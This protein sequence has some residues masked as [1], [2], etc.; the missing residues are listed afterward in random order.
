MTKYF[1]LLLFGLTTICFSQGTGSIVG[2]LTDKDYNNEPLPFANIFID[3]STKGTTSDFDGLYALEN[4]PVGTYSIVYSFVGYETITIDNVLV[5]TKKSTT[6]NVPMRAS[7][8]A[9]DEVFIKTTT[10][11]ESEVSL[12][13]EQK[14]ATTIKQSIGAEELSRKGVSDVA[15]AVTK[16]TGISKQEGSGNIFVRGLGDRY[17]VTT[18]NNLPIPS[19]D[20]SKKNIQL[21]IFDTDIVES[22][23]IDKTYNPENYGDFAGA[24]INIVSKNYRGKGFAEIGIETGANTVTVG[25]KDFYL[26]DGP[27][28]SGF[29]NIKA[30]AFPLNNYNFE[31]S[32]DRRKTTTPVNSGLSFKGGESFDIG[33]DTRVNLFGVGS[34]TNNYSFREG[35]SR[36]GVDVSAVPNADFSFF[37]YSYNTAT[38]LMGN[39]GIKHKNHRLSYNGL[40][41]N[42]SRQQ[43]QEFYGVIDKDDDASEG[44]G[45]IQRATYE[46]TTLVTHQLL[47]DHEFGERLEVNWGG[48][49]NYLENIEPDRRQVTL[50][51]LDAMD[52]E[53]PKSFQFVSS[54]SDNHRFFSKLTEEEVAAN[55]ATTYKF[56]KNEDDDFK[57]KITLGYSGRIK[58]VKFNATQFNFQIFTQGV[59]QPNVDP[60]NVD[61]YF[62][63]E[64]LNNGLYRIR[65]F[66]GTAETPNALDPQY[67]RG[68][69]KIHAGYLNFEYAFSP[70][71]TALLGVRGEQINQF[72]EWS[73]SLDTN[74]DGS[75]LDTFEVLPALSLKYELNEKQN[76]KLAVSKTYTLPQFK[77]RARFLFQEV[78][79]DYF[80]NPGLIA[81]TDYNFDV[82]WEFFPESSEII[83]LG[84]FGKYIQN[85]INS[86]TAVS[87]S[88]DITW[89]NTGEKATAFGAELEVRKSLF[90]H[91]KNS[92]ESILTNSL[93]VG[94]NAAYM[95]TN[96]DL[97]GDKVLAETTEAGFPISFIPTYNS[98]EI[99]G[100]SN[101]VANADI[102]Y[103]KD[104]SE[105]GN[106][107]LTLAA[108]YFSDRIF[109]LGSIGKGNL[110]EKGVATLDFIAKAQLTEN[111]TLALAAKNL[112]NPSIERF[113][114]AVDGDTNPENDG[115]QKTDVTILS[116]KKGYD[117]K[118]SLAYKF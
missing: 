91:E 62:N 38:T 113:Q 53:G 3:G 44:G 88:N 22:I 103:F 116:Y 12:L 97:D 64:N 13:L 89:G 34:F 17:N 102:S 117:L 41:L 52:P 70:K 18:L 48:S 83:S 43:Q 5:E 1:T 112:L 27:S 118:L 65:T 57:G 21:G 49:Y 28:N 79:Q 61:A 42:T 92:E 8:A 59:T 111:I 9:L 23:S 67:Y 101:L 90:E 63:Q 66:R 58:D 104:F 35:V 55:I 7:A 15:T 76:L 69:Q 36:G 40:Y 4:L 73:T 24:N 2:A 72:I 108:N 77:E 54:A 84:A 86:F 85:P 114:E 51:P 14:R 82:K 6:V 31:T 115:F 105:N 80:G 47:G 95:I 20:P 46:R 81:S 26:T 39:L 56:S 10:R 25:E 99:S 37:N 16:V 98:T 106:I 94:F 68:D 32:W 19:N 109:A 87:A 33:E 50:V 11:K 100:A 29:Y 71:F 110:I 96:Q 93:S 107:Q 60:Y 45:F 74:E 75:E 78:N 30:P